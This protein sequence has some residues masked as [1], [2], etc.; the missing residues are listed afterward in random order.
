M[1]ENGI[2]TKLTYVF[3]GNFKTTSVYDGGL[4][5]K[6]K[7]QAPPNWIMKHYKS[8]DFLSNFRMWTPMCIRTKY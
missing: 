8:V 4:A 1:T 7:L 3:F 2:M 6:T 5:P